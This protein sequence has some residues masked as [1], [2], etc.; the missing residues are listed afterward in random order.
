MKNLQEFET[1]RLLLRCITPFDIHE[2][3]KSCSRNEIIAFFGTNHQG[4]EKYKE[5][6]EKG[7]ETDRISL[8]FFLLTEKETGLPIGE[9]GFHT[10]NRFHDRAELF[11]HLLNDECKRKGFMSEAL[12]SVIE[13]GFAVMNLN[14]IQ[15]MV[16]EENTASLKLL[17]K[18][19]FLKEGT[20]RQDY[21]VNGIYENSECYSLLKSE[22]NQSQIKKP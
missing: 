5:M 3:F 2:L 21:L 10:W 22:W 14:R 1:N 11:Y 19:G 7:M 16:A 4:Y 13:Y 6:H 17:I 18:N 12:S 15:A 8:L 9:C 20:S